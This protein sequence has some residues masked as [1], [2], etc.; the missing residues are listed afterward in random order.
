[1]SRSN[2]LKRGTLVVAIPCTDGLIICADKRLSL[3]D[4][5]PVTDGATKLIAVRGHAVVAYTG[6]AS[7]ERTLGASS[8]VLARFD[9]E[10]EIRSY[11]A[12]DSIDPGAS[13]KG[14]AERLISRLERPRRLGEVLP[15]TGLL[16]GKRLLMQVIVFVRRTSHSISGYV[17]DIAYEKRESSIF[18]PS[19]PLYSAYMVPLSEIGT[20]SSE[21]KAFG[22]SE[23]FREV[24]YGTDVRF[25]D[26]RR[27]STIERLRKSSTDPRL[28]S[29]S[30]ALEAACRLTAVSSSRSDL[31]VTNAGIGPT[32][33]CLLLHR[34]KGVFVLRPKKSWLEVPRQRLPRA[35]ANEAQLSLR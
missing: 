13:A 32:V 12:D 18:L 6:A 25:D 10:G 33:D 17:V 4:G 9:L 26:I 29:R 14:L 24:L 5:S 20:A 1:M 11:F 27:N 2:R 34:K 8:L 35:A 23:V 21:P 28:L 30:S 15:P 22:H 16:E 3:A 19:D 7:V 31:L